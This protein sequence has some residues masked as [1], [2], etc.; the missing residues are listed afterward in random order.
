MQLIKS[1]TIYDV[2]IIGSGAGGGMTGLMLANAGIKVLMLEAGPY[3]DP[4]KD[5]QQLKW[6]YESLRRG[7]NATR[8]LGDFDAAYGGWQIEGEP[9]RI[10]PNET[11]WTIFV[12][13]VFWVRAKIAS[14]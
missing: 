7:G 3:F 13:C 4:A 2:V 11:D 9:Y 14:A 6:P 1:K 8:S 12:N 5:S 10:D